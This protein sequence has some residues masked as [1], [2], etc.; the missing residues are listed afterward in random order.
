M[1]PISSSSTCCIAFSFRIVGSFRF[2]G[3]CKGP[4]S[5]PF[6]GLAG[7]GVGVK[8]KSNTSKQRHSRRCQC[9]NSFLPRFCNSQSRRFVSQV[10]HSRS[11]VLQYYERLCPKRASG[12]CRQPMRRID[13]E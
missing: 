1:T 13:L 3:S 4:P 10:S 2:V 6:D 7:V 5:R 8:K 12:V 11:L 9:D